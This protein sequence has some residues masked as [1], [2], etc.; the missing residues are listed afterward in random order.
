MRS[1]DFVKIS[2][3]KDVEHD[4]VGTRIHLSLH[5]LIS[6]LLRISVLQH[7]TMSHVDIKNIL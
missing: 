6:V 1:Y 4:T 2:P 5:F 3:E 7:A